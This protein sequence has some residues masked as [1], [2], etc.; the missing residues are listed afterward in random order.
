MTYGFGAADVFL[1]V[2]QL[3]YLESTGRSG[4]MTRLRKKW[5]FNYCGKKWVYTFNKGQIKD[6]GKRELFEIRNRAFCE[7]ILQEKDRFKAAF[8]YLEKVKP[9]K[10]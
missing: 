2:Y 5:W 7:T 4:L 1:L 3:H 6:P 8:D 9:L 10:H